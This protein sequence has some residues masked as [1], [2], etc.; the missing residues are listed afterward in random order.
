MGAGPVE[1][2]DC[3]EY[4][5]MDLLDSTRERVESVPRGPRNKTTENELTE[6]EF[7]G[8]SPGQITSNQKLGVLRY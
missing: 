3:P 6:K 2:S 4:T 8:V 1:F 5:F 7:M